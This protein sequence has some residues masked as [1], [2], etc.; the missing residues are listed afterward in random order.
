MERHGT[1]VAE[2][3]KELEKNTAEKEVVSRNF[4]EMIIDKDLEEGKHTEIMTRFPLNLC[5]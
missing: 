3:V 1:I 4:I 2:E 5:Q